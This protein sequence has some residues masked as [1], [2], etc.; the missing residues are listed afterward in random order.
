MDVPSLLEEKPLAVD[1]RK[2]K[3]L[4][5]IVVNGRNRVVVRDGVA[6]D[7]VVQVLGSVLIPPH[8]KGKEGVME[9]EIEVEELVE[10]LKGW[11]GEEE[12]RDL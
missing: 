9:G 5:G 4:V 12:V 8:K 10:R 11:M 1:V 7:G 3:G 6:K 2:W